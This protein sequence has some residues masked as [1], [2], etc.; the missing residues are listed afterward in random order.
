MPNKKRVT[1]LESPSRRDF[2][3][4]GAAVAAM[5]APYYVPATAFGKTAPSNRINVGFIG[6][7]NQGFLDLKLFMGHSDCQV[8]ALCDVNKGS[9]R[10]KNLEDIRGREPALKL[11]NETYAK[12]KNVENYDGCDGYRDWRDL[13]ARKDIDAVVVVAP[14]HWHE[15]M[16]IAAAEAGKDIYCEKPLG[17]T[18]GGQQKMV[19]AVRNNN[20]ILQTG[21]HERSNP[22]VRAACDLV[23]S[24]AIGKIEKVVCNVGRHNK[25]S[26]PPGWS[27]MPVPEGFD[28]DMWL[29]PA[30]EA[31]YHEDR[32]FYNFRFI[33]DYAGG[34]T[35]NFGAHSIDIAQ[36]GLGMDGSG[37]VEVEHRYVDYLPEGSLFNAATYLGFRC[38]YPGG[39]SLECRT[40]A[41]SV[42]TAFYGSEGFVSIDNQGQNATVIPHGIAPEMLKERVKYHSGSDHVRNFL[43]CV[44]SREEPNAP[45]EVGHRSASI[46]HIGNIALSMKAKLRWNPKEEKFEGARSEEANQLLNREQRTSWAT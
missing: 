35:T 33:S 31:P 36:W 44:K 8:V 15:I 21:S 28:Y 4:T 29:G 14:D 43:D 10:Y 40:D 3:R 5:A 38:K 20:R 41:A 1:P 25:I 22:Y 6:T 19:E 7:G 27:G 18:I 24:G 23:Q 34:Q 13:I 46:C 30:A 9:G 26:P 17:L 11:V 42:R 12:A 39:I 37:P 16:T 45:V 2:I 32:C